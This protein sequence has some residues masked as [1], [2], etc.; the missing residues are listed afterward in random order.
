MRPSVALMESP[1]CW[2]R[3]GRPTQEHRFV[4]PCVALMGAMPSGTTLIERG[5]TSTWASIGHAPDGSR[6]VRLVTPMATPR[7]NMGFNRTCCAPF[8]SH[9]HTAFTPPTVDVEQPPAASRRPLYF[10]VTRG[11]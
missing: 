2:D 4:R 6:Y 11:P 9:S 10:I 8:P 1:S 3:H 7:F 5:P